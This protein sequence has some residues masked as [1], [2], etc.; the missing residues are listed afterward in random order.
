[1]DPLV[2]VLASYHM[3]IAEYDLWGSGI[4][5]IER[6]TNELDYDEFSKTHLMPSLATVVYAIHIVFCPPLICMPNPKNSKNIIF[7]PR[8]SRSI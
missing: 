7:S 3:T 4:P 2:F 1:M 5:Y 6:V 8:G